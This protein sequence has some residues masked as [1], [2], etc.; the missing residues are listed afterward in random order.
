MNQRAM[1]LEKQGFEELEQTSEYMETH[2][3]K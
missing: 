1:Q 2:Y 3:Y